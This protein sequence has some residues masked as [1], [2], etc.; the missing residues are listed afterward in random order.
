[1][2]PLLDN[3]IA[4]NKASKSTKGLAGGRAPRA[5][6]GGSCPPALGQA[7]RPGGRGDGSQTPSALRTN[8]S[9]QPRPSATFLL[10]LRNDRNQEI[11]L[12]LA[13]FCPGLSNPQRGPANYWKLHFELSPWHRAQSNRDVKVPFLR[14]ARTGVSL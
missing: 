7:A 5:S 12:G 10:S 3:F 2:L 1:M 11:L 13:G 14:G 9:A 4:A 6:R 8:T